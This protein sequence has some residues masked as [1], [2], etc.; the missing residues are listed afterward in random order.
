MI[1]QNQKNPND[2]IG[3][4]E[5]LS[6]NSILTTTPTGQDSAIKEQQP[7]NN[8]LTPNTSD[9]TVT[10]TKPSPATCK[11]Q[12]TLFDPTTNICKTHKVYMIVRRQCK[13]MIQIKEN[14]SIALS[15]KQ[16]HTILIKAIGAID[17]AS[18][19]KI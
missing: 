2:A 15:H 4:I 11:A 10:V 6:D 17:M 7:K 12:G 16:L 8:I 13:D 1:V 9:S 3:V 14:V 19:N 18:N 5:Q